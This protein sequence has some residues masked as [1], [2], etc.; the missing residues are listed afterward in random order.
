MLFNSLGLTAIGC[1]INKDFFLFLSSKTFS[2]VLTFIPKNIIHYR[3]KSGNHQL[4]KI[5]IRDFE[6][7]IIVLGL[8]FEDLG[9]G[10][11]KNEYGQN[12]NPQFKI[13]N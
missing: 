3:T 11:E 1:R 9:W 10:L 7:E 12:T 4:V 13:T 8:G 2:R 5:P 6:F